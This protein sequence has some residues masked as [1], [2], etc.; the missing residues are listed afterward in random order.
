MPYVTDGE[1]SA[2]LTVAQGTPERA[3]LGEASAVDLGLSHFAVMSDGRK[4][5]S[6][7]FLRRAERKL[8]KAQKAA[9]R[10]LDPGRGLRRH[11]GLSDSCPS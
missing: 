11:A 2:R 7:K 5:A 10:R 1:L 9:V 4:V 8:R 3:W 6:P